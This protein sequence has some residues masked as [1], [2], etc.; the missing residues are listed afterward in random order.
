MN[1]PAL[2]TPAYERYLDLQLREAFDLRGCP[3]RF[4]MRGREV[5]EQARPVE[6]AKRRLP[7]KAGPRR[8]Q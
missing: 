5:R 4:V 6:K 8:G 1:S 7:K 3:L 2:L